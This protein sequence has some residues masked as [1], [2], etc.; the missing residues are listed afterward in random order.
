MLSNAYFLAKF[1][2]DT[3]ENEPAK[4]LRNFAKF[5]HEVV[6]MLLECGAEVNFCN[7]LFDTPLHFAVEN[8]DKQI[9]STLIKYGVRCSLKPKF[10]LTLS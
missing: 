5:A 1:R 8:C 10:G 4:N 6:E 7:S 9:V 3:A 2:F